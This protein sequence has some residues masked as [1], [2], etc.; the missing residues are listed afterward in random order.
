MKGKKHCA[1]YLR[2]STQ[3]QGQSHLGLDS[4]LEICKKYIEETGGTLVRVFQDIQSGRKTDRKGLLAAID[5]CKQNGCELVFSKLDRLARNVEFTFKVVNTGIQVHFCDMPQL[6][7]LILGVMAT[8]A[9]YER[10]LISQRTKAALKVLKEKGVKL[11]RPCNA[12][13]PKPTRAGADAMHEKAKNDIR[14]RQAAGIASALRE[15]GHTYRYIAD[16]LNQR[17]LPTPRG[18]LWRPAGVLRLLN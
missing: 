15:H 10:E 5:F 18:S 6:N 7:T 1:I 16:Y 12:R 8:V 14:N 2:V 11:G 17:G 4:Q 9:Q 3:K 13:K